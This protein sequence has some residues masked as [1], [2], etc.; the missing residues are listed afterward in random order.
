MENSANPSA[1]PVDDAPRGRTVVVTGGTRGVGAGIARAFAAAGAQ[2]V[3]CARRPPEQ[4]LDGVTFTPL[5][6]RDAP[7]VRAFFDALP[8][9]DVLVNNAGGTPYRRLADADAERHARVIE[10]NLVT[11]LTASLAAYEQ[12]R[13]TRGSVVMVGSVSGARPSPGSAAYG[14]AKAGLENLAASMAVEW[15]PEVRVNTLVVGM[16]RT[17]RSHL[18]YGGPDGLTAV[19]GTVPLG[20]L[21]TPADVGAAAVFLASGAAAYISGASLLVHGGGERPAFLDAASANREDRRQG[22]LG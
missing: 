16:V 19:S 8:R 20:R 12:L 9:L 10:L 3:V 1:G 15:A 11:P 21:A 13:R 5:D 18:H 22:D 2:V 6:L 17:E 7:A 4:P 14:A